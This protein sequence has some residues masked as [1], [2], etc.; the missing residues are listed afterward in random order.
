MTAAR[1]AFCLAWL[2]A[3]QAAHATDYKVGPGGTHAT[4]QD[5]VSAALAHA[6]NDRVLVHT[7]IYNESVTVPATMTADELTISGG[8]GDGFAAQVADGALDTFVAPGVAQHGIRVLAAGGKVTIDNLHVYGA[9][10]GT[11]A[12]VLVEP[13]GSTQ[14][15]VSGN[16]FEENVAESSGG[17]AYGGAL[18]VLVTSA[19]G[20]AII[21]NRFQNNRATVTF[22][23]GSVQGSALYLY[24]GSTSNCVVTDNAFTATTAEPASSDVSGGAVFAEA[25]QQATLQFERNLIDDVTIGSGSIAI[26]GRSVFLLGG[27]TAALY[28]R[29]NRI[30][31]G[32]GT[33]PGMR[34]QASELEATLNDDCTLVV[35]D[36]L[37]A[38]SALYGIGVFL[39]GGTTAYLTN[40]TIADNA[41]GV[42]VVLGGTMLGEPYLSNS[43]VTNTPEPTD[44][45]PVQLASNRIGVAVPFLAPSLYDY[46][47][48][49]QDTAVVDHGNDLPPGGLGVL[50]VDN[51]VRVYGAHVDIGAHES[52]GRIFA[53]RFD[54]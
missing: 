22:G 17:T 42:V 36:T 32:G 52:R 12:G 18:A 2:L 21:G 9:A 23:T 30:H 19:A 28:V 51:G 4:I 44:L 50:D 8:W 54:D 38:Q 33:A 15:I 31:A 27:D 5:A 11:G 3:A 45:L 40:L 10:T 20:V 35:S 16:I 41:K 37:V 26:Y 7:G 39:N 29:G 1:H 14:V 6:G 47:L 43:I 46:S 53:H 48:G 24:C 49:K 34:A 13:A 25:L